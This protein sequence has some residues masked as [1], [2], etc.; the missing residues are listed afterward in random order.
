M[1]RRSRAWRL[2]TLMVAVVVLAAM[3]GWG[4][5]ELEKP[6]PVAVITEGASPPMVIWS[7]GEAT[8]HGRTPYPVASLEDYRLALIVK[9][10]DGSTTYHLRTGR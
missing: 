9:W 5:S 4:R 10:S 8:S 1:N 7:D 2:R 3:L 6:R